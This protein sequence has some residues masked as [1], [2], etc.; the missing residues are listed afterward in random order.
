M[1]I[2]LKSPYGYK[3]C[4]C[5]G[6]SK[7]YVSKFITHSYNQAKEMKRHYYRFPPFRC[8]TRKLKQ[9]KWY[10]FAIT[11]QEVIRGIWRENPF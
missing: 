1:K 3:V 10:I 9:L 6:K 2:D 8:A 11:K 5:V 7:H 4:Y